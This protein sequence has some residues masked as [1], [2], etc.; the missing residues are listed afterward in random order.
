MASAASLQTVESEEK[1]IVFVV[2]GDEIQQL[3][4]EHAGPTRF[5]QFLLEKLKFAGGPVSGCINFKLDRGALARAKPNLEDA[6]FKRFRYIWLPAEHA[7]YVAKTTLNEIEFAK[8][9]ER[10]EAG[11]IQ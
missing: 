1:P 3:N 6:R 2:T 11:T 7:R 8:W 4:A 9:N 10:H 5:N